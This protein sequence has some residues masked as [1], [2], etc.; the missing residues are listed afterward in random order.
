MG[1]ERTQIWLAPRNV[2]QQTDERLLGEENR[3]R[4]SSSDIQHAYL[5]SHEPLL[6]REQRAPAR[7]AP[8]ERTAIRSL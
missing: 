7:L 6:L 2:S 5:I 4:P 8:N 1:A 3:K